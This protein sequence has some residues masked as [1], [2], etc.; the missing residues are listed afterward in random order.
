MSTYE[1]DDQHVRRIIDNW[2]MLPADVAKPFKDALE[3]QLP[4]PTPTKLGAIVR[5][6]NGI[7]LLTDPEDDMSWTSTPGGIWRAT[8][9]IGPILEVLFE[10]V[11]V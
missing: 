5:T 2:D 4:P 8:E 1:L 3:S 7:Y 9:S 11:D 6:E 10:G